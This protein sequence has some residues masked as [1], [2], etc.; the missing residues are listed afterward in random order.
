VTQLIKYGEECINLS[1]ESWRRRARR[2]KSGTNRPT[3]TIPNFGLKKGSGEEEVRGTTLRGKV[4]CWERQASTERP[5][6]DP[7]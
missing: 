1:G 4:E 3:G 7:S 6:V 2:V 5:G